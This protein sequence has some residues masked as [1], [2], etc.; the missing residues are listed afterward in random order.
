[1]QD[2]HPNDVCKCG[3]Y[4]HQHVDGTGRCKLGSLCSPSPCTE[5]RLSRP[6]EPE[7]PRCAELRGR[8]V[9]M[10]TI[11]KGPPSRTIKTAYECPSCDYVIPLQ[12]F[13]GTSR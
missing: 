4:R 9:R 10:Q 2:N 8:S 5:F 11:A 7:C 13:S 1:M 12:V 3:D 6:T